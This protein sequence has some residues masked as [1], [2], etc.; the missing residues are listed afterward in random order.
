MTVAVSWDR[1]ASSNAKGGAKARRGTG[2]NGYAVM[3][4][5]KGVW[6]LRWRWRQE[7]TWRNGS[8]RTATEARAWVELARAALAVGNEPP[9]PPHYD[10]RS[11]PRPP[12]VPVVADREESKAAVVKAMTTLERC[13]ACGLLRP[14]DPCFGE[15]RAELYAARRGG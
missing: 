6:R 1:Q 13:D 14:C 12:R 5:S 2:A 11:D 10:R 8:A 9:A 3:Q 4:P 7:T 15:M